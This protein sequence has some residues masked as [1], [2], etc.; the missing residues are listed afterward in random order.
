MTNN[1]GGFSFENPPAYQE[2]EY[3][4]VIQLASPLH[5]ETMHDRAKCCNRLTQIALLSSIESLGYDGYTVQPICSRC[6]AALATAA[7][8]VTA[9]TSETIEAAT[10]Q[11]VL[12]A[13]LGLEG[14]EEVLCALR[15]RSTEDTD[16]DDPEA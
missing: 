11:Q 7:G 10:I 15:A 1:A 14:A 8:Q 16:G 3:P 12:A 5:C 6:I 9:H 13:R 2:S 4:M